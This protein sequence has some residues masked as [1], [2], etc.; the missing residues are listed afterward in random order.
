[1]ETNQA[2]EQS[3]V[4]PIE[5]LWTNPQPGMNYVT[6]PQE[7]GT[8]DKGQENTEEGKDKPEGDQA[9][10]GQQAAGDKQ[11]EGQQ[12]FDETAWIKEKTAGKYEKWDDLWQQAEKPAELTFENEQAKAIYEHLQKGET[13]KVAEFLVLQQA[14]NGLDK[15]SDEEVIKMRM[16]VEEPDNED[17]NGTFD[18]DFEKPEKGEMSDEQ[19][20]KELNRYNRRLKKVADEA[21]A[22][23]GERKTELSLPPLTSQAPAADPKAELEKNVTEAMATI[24]QSV[25]EALPQVNEFTFTFNN[26][27]GIELNSPYKFTEQDKKEASEA[28]KDYGQFFNDRY[29]TEGGKY[30]GQKLL[31]DVLLLNNFQQILENR[32][33]EAVMNDRLKSLNDRA[34][35]TAGRELVTPPPADAQALKALEE[36]KAKM[37]EVWS[38]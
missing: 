34:N 31:N 25:T 22:F 21:R 27:K 18:I 20:Q 19:Y 11:E 30:D 29:T 6:K 33:T 17:I 32:I 15:A 26:D 3:N 35:Y 23:L 38:V 16:L 1:M 36:N 5:E 24:Y 8:G 12:A 37:Q 13:E 14:L 4:R 28:L 9:A 2:Q 10:N 7:E